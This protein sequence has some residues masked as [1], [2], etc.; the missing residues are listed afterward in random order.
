M[1]AFGLLAVSAHTPSL[2]LASANNALVLWHC[3]NS[4]LWLTAAKVHDVT[5]QVAQVLIPQPLMSLLQLVNP[6]SKV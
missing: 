5:L 3:T 2:C 4:W 6:C 1:T